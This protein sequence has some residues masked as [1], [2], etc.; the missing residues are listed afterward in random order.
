MIIR[1]QVPIFLLAIAAV[2]AP[3]KPAFAQ[4]TTAPF[5]TIT[6]APVPPAQVET[7]SPQPPVAVPASD[8]A[9]QPPSDNT[10]PFDTTDSKP[11]PE[12]KDP[13]FPEATEEIIPEATPAPMPNN[14]PPLRPS[15]LPKSLEME[16]AEVKQA[17]ANAIKNN[18][19]SGR[20]STTLVSSR[21]LEHQKIEIE[22]LRE[23]VACA[24]NRLNAK[25]ISLAAFFEIQKQSINAELAA[26]TNSNLRN[27]ILRK[28]AE[29][30][31]SVEVMFANQESGR[32]NNSSSVQRYTA[33]ELK[34]VIDQR[35]HWEQLITTPVSWSSSNSVSYASSGNLTGYAPSSPQYCRPASRHRR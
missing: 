35:Q 15:P 9:S 19:Q 10:P 23:A 18:R 1:Y 31:R 16:I 29:S 33:E 27:A 12:V 28:A 17:A 2:V 5:P 7:T 25:T 26:A 13:P 3:G 30:C 8:S 6:D 21:A 20:Y 14:P 32:N 34:A 4:E 24:K 22:L 11:A